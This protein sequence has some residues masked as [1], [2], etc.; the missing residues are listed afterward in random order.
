MEGFFNLLRGDQP[1]FNENVTYLGHWFCLAVAGHVLD[2]LFYDDLWY[3]CLFR[4]N[5]TD[6]PAAQVFL[7]FESIINICFLNQAFFTEDFAEWLLM[8]VF[9]Q[10]G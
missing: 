9:F 7:F 10:P 2:S 6:T 1:G 8:A 3:V 4:K 5:L